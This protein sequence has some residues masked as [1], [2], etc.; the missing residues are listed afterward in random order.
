MSRTLSALLGGK[1]MGFV[2]QDRRGRLLFRYDQ[3]WRSAANAIPL[4]LSMPLASAEHGHDATLAFLSGLL[5]D[6]RDV[7]AAWGRHFHVSPRNAFALLSHVGE[8]CAGAI[9]FV[10][11]ERLEAVLDDTRWEVR[12]IEEPEIES[13]LRTLR[14]DRSAWHAPHDTGR[15]GLAGAQAKTALLYQ[16]GKWGVP[17]GRAPTTHIL[18][19]P[20]PEFDGYVENEH[21]CLSLA[22]ELSL[23]AVASKVVRFGQEVTIVVERYDRAWTAELAAASQD[24]KAAFESLAKTTPILRLHQEDLCQA[25]GVP[26]SLKYQNE[27]G[28]SPAQVVELLR[29][30]S[31][32]PAEDV[33]FFVRAL[34]FNWL[35]A[36]T[37]AHA[38]NYSILLGGGG[39]AR[40]GPLY[41][42]ASALPYDHLDSQR[43]TLAMKIGSRYRLCDVSVDQ[44]R[45]LAG[46]L[47]LDPVDVQEDLLELARSLTAAIDRVG[48]QAVRQGLD[49]AVVA[50]LAGRLSARA[51]ECRG[52]LAG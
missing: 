17:S 23:P 11:D 43:L 21:Y 37:D 4:S 29:S 20:L 45:T 18:K 15:F 30:Q 52:Q 49:P 27:G 39:R 46:E 5:P 9:Q 51:E 35:I 34:A 44:W 1:I 24:N 32:R 13:R 2:E 36:G 19:P 25:L 6:N 42:L 31:S 3:A 26:P 47:R 14:K 12:W 22:R 7:V 41:D 50:R 48:E 40:L 10:R 8:D 16:N 38:K 33:R 28:P